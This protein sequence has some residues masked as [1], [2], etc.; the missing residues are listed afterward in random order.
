M[1]K[2]ATI[3]IVAVL[4]VGAFV[5]GTF[6]A[7]KMPWARTAFSLG[8]PGGGP[9]GGL[10]AQERAKVQSMTDEERRS[11]FEERM[12]HDGGA[13]PGGRGGAMMVEG[14]IVS[15]ATDSFSI[16]TSDGGSRTVYVDATTVIGFTSGTKRAVTAGDNIIAFVQ[17]EADNVLSAEAVVVK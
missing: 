5:G 1:N 15:V 7:G 16:K 14:Q 11:Y 17:P 8:G 9:M 6:L 13:G 2:A 3:A 10:S 4:V 12:G